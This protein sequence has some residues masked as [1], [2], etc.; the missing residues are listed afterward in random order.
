M[1]KGSG[2]VITAIS[3]DRNEFTIIKQLFSLS[4]MRGHATQCWH[5]WSIDG[6]EYIIKDSWINTRW[7][8]NKIDIL[9]EI[10]DVV[11]IP[12]LVKGWDVHLPDGMKDTT[13]L[14]W[15]R[16]HTGEEWVHQQLL[17]KEVAEPLSTF[18][19]KKE[20]VGALINMIEGISRLLCKDM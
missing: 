15:H 1:M 18:C 8:L 13:S 3:V 2:S 19:S 6:Q 20:L 7:Q 17:I 14:H 4:T 16:R 9:R 11:N 12:T 5:V 10:S